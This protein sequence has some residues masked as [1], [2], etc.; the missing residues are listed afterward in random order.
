MKTI[1]VLLV[2]VGSVAGSVVAQTTAV[3]PVTSTMKSKKH[4][5]VQAVVPL[6][7]PATAVDQGDGTFKYVDNKGAAWIYRKTPFGVSR[8]L[9]TA[10]TAQ[11]TGQTP[12]GASKSKTVSAPAAAPSSLT[13]D[14]NSKVNAVANGDKIEFSHSTPFGVTKWQKSKNDLTPDEQ[15][16]WD[17]EQA[18]GQTKGNQ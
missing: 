3:T 7:I 1:L 5:K 13:E 11:N 10:V 6:T 2:A 4:A 17:R 15:K 12:F 18:A 16:I 8:S 9:E 14:A